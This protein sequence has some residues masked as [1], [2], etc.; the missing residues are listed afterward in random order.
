MDQQTNYYIDAA[1]KEL[2]GQQP[3]S[4][5]YA[6]LKWIQ[7]D[8]AIQQVSFEVGMGGCKTRAARCNDVDTS[9]PT[10][11]ERRFYERIRGQKP[12]KTDRQIKAVK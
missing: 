7:L 10:Y 8:G 1:I 6:G 11:E 2:Y 12:Q 9:V 4:R 5:S 3:Q